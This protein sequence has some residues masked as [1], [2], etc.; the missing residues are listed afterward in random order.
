MHLKAERA[1]AAGA[2]PDQIQLMFYTRVRRRVA[3]LAVGSGVNL[4]HR[5]A[6]SVRGLNLF[7]LGVDEHRDARASGL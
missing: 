3:G 1:G 4:D 6:N 5:R 2:R 7:R